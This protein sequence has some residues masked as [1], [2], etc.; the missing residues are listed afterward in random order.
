MSD[1]RVSDKRVSAD[2]VQG[3]SVTV[4]TAAPCDRFYDDT[5]EDVV[6]RRRQATGGVI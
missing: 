4:P 2:A 5:R 6:F 3:Q 1:K